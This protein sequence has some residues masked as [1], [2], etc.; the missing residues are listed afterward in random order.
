MTL[1]AKSLLLPFEVFDPLGQSRLCM[2]ESTETI[3]NKV[4]LWSSRDSRRASMLIL[5]IR[6]L[7]LVLA[8]KLMLEAPQMDDGSFQKRAEKNQESHQ[9][10]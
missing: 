2:H 6:L 3:N 7:S 5:F 10:S 1:E 8:L 4:I 9:S